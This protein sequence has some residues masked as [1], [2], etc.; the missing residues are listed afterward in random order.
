MPGFPGPG[1]M[2][3]RLPCPMTWHRAMQPIRYF[4]RTFVR[5]A[6][7]VTLILAGGGSILPAS[8]QAP[9]ANADVLRPEVA[10]PLTAADEFIKAGKFGEAQVKIREAEQVSN[11]TPL[12]NYMIN[13]MRGIAAIG[14][15]DETT[16]SR[17]FE[18]V[19]ASGRSPITEQQQLAEALAVMYFKSGDY[20][21]AVAWNERYLKDG[22]TNPEMRMQLV[23]S[24]YLAEDYAGAAT[25]LRAM[26]DA[27]EKAKVTP[28]LERLQLL[29]SCYVKL[30][31]AAGYASVVDKLLVYYP[32]REYWV[33]A[34][35][36]VENRPGFPQALVLD[37][38]RLQEATGCL[39]HRGTVHRDGP[40]CSKGRI[41]GRG[42]TDPRHGFRGRYSGHRC[43]SRC[44]AEAA[45]CGDEAGR[46]R[47]K[48]VRA[49]CEG[50]CRGEGRNG[51]R[52]RR[53]RDGHRRKDGTGSRPDG[54]GNPEGRHPPDRR[55]ASASRDR[56]PRGR[57]EGEGDPGIPGGEGRRHVGSRAP[58]V[59][60]RCSARP[61]D[62]GSRCACC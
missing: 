16:A 58:L 1:S 34:I 53:V 26:L 52:Q 35:R 9:D 54:A 17:S 32:K 61:A 29:M 48:G 24:R 10:K 60:P 3:A 37:V 7:V 56:L 43:R 36:R 50:R 40:A 12:E 2:A 41:A 21:K 38:L 20:K 57:P 6:L 27:D 5:C 51:A 8:A 13:R 46:R 55:G 14:A 59:D 44:A 47:R 23:R 45:Q 22:G 15:G 28:P 25:D 62:E 42:E 31:D 33:D 19:I 39:D 30:N 18:A 11:R 4:R 49:E